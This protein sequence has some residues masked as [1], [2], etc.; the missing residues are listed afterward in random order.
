MNPLNIS[1]FILLCAS[2]ASPWTLE[3]D[4]DSRVVEYKGK[5]K[6]YLHTRYAKKVE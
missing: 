3:Y 5:S 1:K 2:D 4:N 6:A